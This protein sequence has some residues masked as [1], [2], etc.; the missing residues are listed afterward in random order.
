MVSQ[1]ITN[2]G[3]AIPM[4]VLQ[5]AGATSSARLLCPY[6]K[7]S[8]LPSHSFMPPGGSLSQ[9]QIEAAEEFA[10]T[11]LE[12]LKTERGVHAETAIAGAARIAGMFLFR[13]F[14]FP[15]KDAKPGSP[16]LSDQADE[17]GPRLIQILAGVLEH[18]GVKL[19][20]QKLG[21]SPSPQ[22]QP[23]LHFLETQKQLEPK[24][25][26]IIRRLG[27]SLQ[28]S[29]DSAALAT[30]LLIQQTARTLDPNI[31]FSIAVYGFIEGS[32]T[33]PEPIT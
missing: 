9:K 10:R 30:A 28:D 31:A 25:T 13:S 11:T 29:A 2:Y 1:L 18:I 32:K 19:D 15:L 14:N 6:L 17:Q 3:L 33:V 24:Y 5:Q 16:V 21:N 12:T 23:L 7:P 4:F 27:L 8:R 26:A 22:N 20:K